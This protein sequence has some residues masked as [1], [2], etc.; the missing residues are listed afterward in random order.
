LS[1]PDTVRKASRPKKSCEVDAALVVA[2]QVMQVERRDAEQF[3]GAFAVGGGDD[4]GVHPEELA[5]VEEAVDGLGDG[6]AHAVAA[7]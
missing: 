7:R 5:F 1:W 3:A 2:R 4:R 6:V